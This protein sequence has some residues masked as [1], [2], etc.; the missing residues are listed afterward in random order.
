MIDQPVLPEGRDQALSQGTVRSDIT[1]GLVDEVDAEVRL[2]G[3]VSIDGDADGL[4]L[5]RAVE[6][7]GEGA[8][9]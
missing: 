3:G 7:L 1:V 4:A 6:L 9:R 2:D 5:E 8:D